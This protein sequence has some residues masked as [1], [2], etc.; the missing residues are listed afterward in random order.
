[1]EF[2]GHRSWAVIKYFS[3][4]SIWILGSHH[5]PRQGSPGI[6]PDS[7][8]GIA[9][10]LPVCHVVLMVFPRNLETQNGIQSP[11]HSI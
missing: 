4:N 2:E 9:E 6:F 8:V 1:M 10:G 3:S 5:G 11:F 7:H